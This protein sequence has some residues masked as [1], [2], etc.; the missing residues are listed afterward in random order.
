LTTVWAERFREIQAMPSILDCCQGL[1]EGRFAPGEVLL[2]EGAMSGKLYFLI[3]GEVEIV[4][5]DYRIN[6]VSDPGAIFGEISILLGLP[7]MATVRAVT[8]T[9]AHVVEGGSDFLQ[10]HKELAFQLSKVLA[11]RL[12]GVTGYLVDLKR[13]FEDQQGHLGIVDEVLESLVH[14][15]PEEFTPGSDRDPNTAL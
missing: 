7:H 12:H 14:Q 15:Q 1:P 11:Q 13:Q 6:L 5:G 9:R 4:K 2:S 10:T 8:E 3:D